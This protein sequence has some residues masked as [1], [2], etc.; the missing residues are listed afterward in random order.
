MTEPHPTPRH[1]DLVYDV[2]LH[3]AQDTAFYLRKG[4]RVVAFEANPELAR[5]ARERFAEEVGA[6]R[7]VV[8]EGA[9]VEPATLAAGTT[10]VRFFANDTFSEWGTVCEDWAERNVRLGTSN[11]VV[12]VDAIDFVAVLREHGVPHYMKID[13]EGVDLVC[14]EAL[15]AFAQRPKY[16]SIESDK[17]SFERLQHEVD[18]L[19]GLGYDAF[20]AVEQSSIPVE[21]RPPEPAREGAFVDHRFEHGASGLFGAELPGDWVSRD[22]V[23]RA[24][25]GIFRGYRVAGDDGFLSRSKFPGAEIVRSIVRRVTKVFTGR[26]IAGWYD[27]HA[28]RP[29]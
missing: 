7:L 23:L 21:Q 28:R 9:I 14:V 4:F 11:T 22:A 27:T 16:L 26:D 2:G 17:T 5:A 1:D 13:I 24:Y 15:H 29:D 12:E 19:A 20:Q 8:V 10:R 25:R 6:G 18:S 3:T